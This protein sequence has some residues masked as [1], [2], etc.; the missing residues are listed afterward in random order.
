MGNR[1]APAGLGA[2]HLGHLAEATTGVGRQHRRGEVG[3][4]TLELVALARHPE[5]D[6]QTLALV[7]DEGAVLAGRDVLPEHQPGSVRGGAG[8]DPGRGS[9]ARG[10]RPLGGEG[11][12]IPAG[13]GERGDQVEQD[14]AVLDPQT[15]RAPV[16]LVVRQPPVADPLGRQ[17]VG[18]DLG[19][20]TAVL[21]E[22]Q[23]GVEP[24]RD[25]HPQVG[26]PAVA[27]R[28]RPTRTPYGA[29]RDLSADRR[30][31]SAA[32]PEEV[33]A[34]LRAPGWPRR[35]ARSIGRPDRG[36]PPRSGWRT[37]PAGAVRP[38][39]CRRSAARR[40]PG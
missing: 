28:Q 24:G 6:P 11:V 39:R 19:E 22:P 14:A 18:D 37:A 4:Q 16:P 15:Q 32:Q 35:P 40:Q 20:A 9:V 26:D 33:G 38:V 30:A 10:R 25:R 12:G 7:G 2:Q 5:V 13:L 34:H 29:R 1:T 23:L 8:G 21:T 3:D 27:G 36:T 31:R 17:R